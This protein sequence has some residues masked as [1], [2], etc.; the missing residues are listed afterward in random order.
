[1]FFVFVFDFSKGGWFQPLQTT[2]PDP[3]MDRVASNKNGKIRGNY[4]PLMKV[5]IYNDDVKKIARHLALI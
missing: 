4:F 3:P 1:L 2:P 5:H